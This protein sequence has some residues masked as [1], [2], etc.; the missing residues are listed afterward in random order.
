MDTS[1]SRKTSPAQKFQIRIANFSRSSK[2]VPVSSSSSPTNE[3]GP[4]LSLP[5]PYH[6]RT[7][8]EYVKLPVTG[9][10]AVRV[11]DSR[12]DYDHIFSYRSRISR[13]IEDGTADSFVIRVFWPT[14][15]VLERHKSGVVV[16]FQNS[17]VDFVVI[18]VLFDVEIGTVSEILASTNLVKKLKPYDSGDFKARANNA[19][20]SIIGL[21]NSS[22]SEN[23]PLR[24]RIDDLQVLPQVDY[25]LSYS[26]KL[27]VQV[28]NF[29]RPI[30][31]KLQYFSFN[32][33]TLELADMPLEKKDGSD[34]DDVTI[35]Q[36]R[37]LV[38][39]LKSHLVFGFPQGNDQATVETWITELNLSSELSEILQ[40]QVES[41]SG[42]SA[43]SHNLMMILS[44]LPITICLQS[45]KFS[46]VIWR[47]LFTS[48][49]W[50]LMSSL[51]LYRVF[52]EAVLVIIEWQ[53]K[54]NLPA[55]KDVSATIQQL[56]LRLHQACN[57]PGQYSRLRG[58]V[59][60]HESMTR[61]HPDYIRFY[62][63]LWLVANDIIIGAT[64]GS[65]II[66]N[67]D[68]IVSLIA[69]CI[70]N[71]L[72]TGL[73]STIEWL[74]DWPGGLKLNNELVAFFG[75]LFLWV[76]EFWSG[77]L[78]IIRPFLPDFIFL[79]GI[80]GFFGATF[81][82]A[83]IADFISFLT[84]QIYS[85]YLASARIYNWQLTVLLSLFHLFRGK[86]RN[87][88]RNRID[89]CV[90]DLDQL[91]LGTLLFTL[92]TFLL[93][94]V[95]VFYLTFASARLGIIVVNAI[96]ESALV[97][98]NHFPLFA[99]M[100]RLKDPKRLPGGI[101][102]EYDNVPMPESSHVYINIR[103]IPLPVMTMFAQYFHLSKRIQRQYLSLRVISLLLS[104][105][106]VPIQRSSH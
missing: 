71:V 88:L 19:K 31:R 84:L 70:N 22:K 64:V 95:L 12:Y 61:Y 102:F 38:E 8:E 80:S 62:N 10:Q 24:I 21:L 87:V 36:K 55:M 29:T 1:K 79:I 81:S 82:I 68:H 99:I 13:A 74:M 17:P 98:L 60:N 54:D 3:N 37:K 4:F 6:Y 11:N 93:P 101:K 16:G 66:E 15:L 44:Q 40:E 92:L 28:I 85:C 49:F 86:R 59:Q 14:D 69:R 25:Q 43:D 50:I 46:L 104:G 45:F 91:L 48:I 106:F 9:G 90:Y 30:F 26:G 35:V 97:L 39:K 65:Y 2:S 63:S 7:D 67:Q 41:F 18:S 32:P 73:R 96:L 34:K 20:L 75:E 100:L 78:R 94:T 76:I 33:I 58:Q 27:S 57:W 89:S 105:Q 77:Y 52:L 42:Q 5:K 56:D 72:T 103:S 23:L 83:L 47:F 53:P 51:M